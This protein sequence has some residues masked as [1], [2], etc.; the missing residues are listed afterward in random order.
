MKDAQA[1]ETATLLLISKD[2]EYMGDAV[3]GV[4]QIA[5]K[6]NSEGKVIPAGCW[7]EMAE[8]YDEVI[9]NAQTAITAL[10]ADDMALAERAIL[11][12]PV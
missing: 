12:Q 4:C 10:G 6:L 1:K 5:G 9:K 7:A 2:L 3:A 11:K 8:L